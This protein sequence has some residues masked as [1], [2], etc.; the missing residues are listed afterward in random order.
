MPKNTCVLMHL[1]IKKSLKREGG[2]GRRETAN[3]SDFKK[4]SNLRTEVQRLT[5]D[6]TVGPVGAA[7][8][9]GRA[10]ALHVHD[11][12]TV[13]IQCLALR[14]NR[15][16]GAGELCHPFC[17][18]LR[19]RGRGRPAERTD[20]QMILEAPS[21]QRH[22]SN[23]NMNTENTDIRPC[24]TLQRGDGP[25]CPGQ[26]TRE[27]TSFT[28]HLRVRLGVLHQVENDPCRLLRPAALAAGGHSG[29]LV[30]VARHLSTMRKFNQGKLSRPCAIFVALFSS[31][32]LGGVHIE[33]RFW[34]SR[35]HH[36]IMV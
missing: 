8:L 29:V 16:K 21:P 34:H 20:G 28:S 18:Y 1:V 11:V 4:R 13:D 32:Y 10:V 9:L 2:G 6:A 31:N 5:V 23:E 30:L 15:E 35:T 12:E 7:P 26:I 24:R 27:M 33:V 22:H 36:K 3:A 25:S 14:Y 19:W 17:C